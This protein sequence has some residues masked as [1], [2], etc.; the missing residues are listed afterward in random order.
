MPEY[1]EIASTSFGQITVGAKTYG[2][3]IYLLADG[4]VKKRKKRLA[5]A[6]YGTSHRIGPD[7]LERVCQGGPEVL[8][9]GTGQYGAVKLTE[10][11]REFLRQRGVECCALAT[12][13]AIGAYND[14]R[15][16]KA[17]LIHVTC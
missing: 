6:A 7:E 13:Q 17:A 16:P 4:K 2:H 12:P 10:E 3:D 11:G 5:K 8:F 9:I 1:P 14:C 15:Q